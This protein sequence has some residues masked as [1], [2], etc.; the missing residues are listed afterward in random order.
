[1]LYT[2]K[3]EKMTVTIDSRGAQL[4]SITGA[5]GTE[6]LWDGDKA[7]WGGRAPQLF[8]YVGRCTEGRCTYLGKSYNMPKHGFARDCEF[9]PVIEEEADRIILGI[10]DTPETR[11][12]Y[13]FHFDFSVA[14]E[15]E[16][17][18]LRITY[19]VENRTNT[20]MFFGLGG[21]PG[22]RIP[23]EPGKSFTDYSLTFAQPCH[24]YRVLLS[25]NYMIS[26][27]S[28]P[29]YLE[30]GTTLPLRHD[31]FD[32]DAII[33]DHMDKTVTLSAGEGSHGV[34]VS[35]PKM[36]YLGVWHTTGSPD[37]PFVCLEP[38][39]S[40]PSRDSI[41]EELTQQGDLVRLE[42]GEIYDNSWTITIF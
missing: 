4:M 19:A 23:M 41:V 37:A 8:P 17:A 30:N 31:L 16:D 42:S 20:D 27:K 26:G 12:V 22:F 39:V 29:Y 3:N 40:L 28:V 18:T 21:H 15:L 32:N 24:P 2:I 7:Y 33:F 5:D 36:R 11:E 10:T 25:E 9:V 35:I 14:Y 13:P 38:W 34:T 6:Y 1:M